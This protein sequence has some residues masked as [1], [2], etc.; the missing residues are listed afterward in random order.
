MTALQFLG[1]MA[2]SNY[3]F[4]SGLPTAA[5]FFPYIPIL[6]YLICAIIWA[7]K[8]RLWSGTKRGILVIVVLPLFGMAAF[9]IP[10]LLVREDKYLDQVFLLS[11]AILTVLVIG[12]LWWSLAKKR[13]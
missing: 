3:V 4:A 8:S 1:L 10:L 13:Q 2:F 12:A 5:L 6:T 11:S 7:L 9:F